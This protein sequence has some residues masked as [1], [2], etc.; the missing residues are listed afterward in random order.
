MSRFRMPA[1]GGNWIDLR[2]E[3]Y[4]PKTRDVD[5]THGA[6]WYHWPEPAG[7]IHATAMAVSNIF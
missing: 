7:D 4:G 1:E 5:W 6:F 3:I 2:N